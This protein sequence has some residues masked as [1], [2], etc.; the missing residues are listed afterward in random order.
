MIRNIIWDLDGTLFDTY[1][2]ILRGFQLAL[3]DFGVAIPEEKVR[4]QAQ[5]SLTLYAE[6][7]VREHDLDAESLRERYLSYYDGFPVEEQKPFPGA[8]LIVSRQT[9]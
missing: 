9:R 6:K 4:K 5:K 7:L 8:Y 3:A 2:A 1:P